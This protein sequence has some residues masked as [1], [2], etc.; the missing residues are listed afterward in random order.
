MGEKSDIK[1][2]NFVRGKST[3]DPQGR[4]ES[5]RKAIPGVREQATTLVSSDRNVGRS[6]SPRGGP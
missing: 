6:F 2:A 3:I 5:S 4:R 1:G